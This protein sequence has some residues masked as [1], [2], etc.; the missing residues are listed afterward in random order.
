M[1][2]DCSLQESLGLASEM[3]LDL[4]SLNSETLATLLLQ[5]KL[6]TELYELEGA[7]DA[8]FIAKQELEDAQE[9]SEAA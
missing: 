6:G 5:D 4:D 9:E 7:I 1:E 2:N 8:Y 3:C